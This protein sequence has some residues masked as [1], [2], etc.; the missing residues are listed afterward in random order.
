VS[1][2]LLVVA[3]VCLGASLRGKE[4]LYTEGSLK[5]LLGAAVALMGAM[6]CAKIAG[7]K[8]WQHAVVIGVLG[9]A[10]LGQGV[11]LFMERP[12]S[13]SNVAWRPKGEHVSDLGPDA[14]RLGE[15]G[16]LFQREKLA[17][18]E[19]EQ[20]ILGDRQGELWEQLKQTPFSWMKAEI[21][22]EQY[23]LRFRRNQIGS[24]EAATQLQLRLLFAGVVAL[25]AVLPWKRVRAIAV[26][27]MLLT[28]LGLGFW[29]IRETPDPFIDVYVFQ[30]ESA[31]ALLQGRNPYAID[32]TNIYGDGIAVYAQELQKN[33]R[34]DFGFPYMPLSLLM[35]VPGYLLGDHRISQLAALVAAAGFIAYSR[36]GIV[37]TLAALLLLTTSRIFMVIEL[38]WSEPLV[39]FWLAAT[40]WCACRRPRWVPYALGCFLAMKQYTILVPAVAALLVMPKFSWRG[41][42]VLMLK[43]G[44]VAVAVTL[45][46]VLWDFNAFM[47][48]AVT[49]QLKQPLREDALSFLIWFYWHVDKE[50]VKGM[51][52][53]AFAGAGVFTALSIWLWP[54]NGGGFA[55][56]VAM[57]FFA[58]FSL[59]R[60]AFCNYY[61]LVIAAMCCAIA[62]MDQP[63]PGGEKGPA[64][65][66]IPV[67]PTVPVSAEPAL[68]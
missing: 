48:S 8:S 6:G 21:E 67:E 60:Q 65:P 36:P 18:L 39:V 63:E 32:F 57:V 40:V 50:A 19:R 24:I 13:G 10:V 30:Q 58:F 25:V 1:I 16:M 61:F 7:D 49:L 17:E 43:A 53:V 56:A 35:V 9:A 20:N 44:A 4:W 27:V 31:Q 3:V 14:P 15:A 59:N 5:G 29:V 11:L 12:G 37:A 47:R 42:V 38:A 22:K 66:T 54:R 28:F 46:F 41:Y 52:W 68:R 33:G 51:G 26:P 55:A 45:P 23:T 34:V 64:F 2:C 62:A